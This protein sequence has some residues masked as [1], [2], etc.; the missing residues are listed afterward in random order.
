MQRLP[1]RWMAPEAIAERVFNS[2]T[3]VYSF[4]VVLVELH[5]KGS[6]WDSARDLTY[7]GLTDI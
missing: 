2:Q 3:D 5:M 6:L 1:L 4:G 7:R